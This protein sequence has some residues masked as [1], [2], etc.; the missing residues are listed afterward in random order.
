MLVAKIIPQALCR[1]NLAW[2]DDVPDEHLK[3]WK[4]WLLELPKLNDYKGNVYH[5]SYGYE[6]SEGPSYTFPVMLVKAATVL[7]RMFV[8]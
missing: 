5:K 4:R 3:Y 8:S 7:L 6:M 2:D 1:M